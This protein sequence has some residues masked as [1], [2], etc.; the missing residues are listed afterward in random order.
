MSHLSSLIVRMRPTNS[1]KSETLSEYKKLLLNNVIK[2]FEVIGP[3]DRVGRKHLYTL[4]IDAVASKPITQH[5]YPLSPAMQQ[6]LSCEID[7]IL[8]QEIIMQLKTPSP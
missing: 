3:E 7:E 1:E 2:C 4:H 5:Q 8:Q 6:F